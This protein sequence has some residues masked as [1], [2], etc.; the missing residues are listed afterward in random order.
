MLGLKNRNTGL[1]LAWSH[2]LD[3]WARERLLLYKSNGKDYVLSTS[4]KACLTELYKKFLFMS[5]NSISKLVF[6]EIDSAVILA[7]T[8]IKEWAFSAWAQQTLLNNVICT[9]IYLF[10][11]S[12][13]SFGGV[14]NIPKKW[15]KLFDSF[16]LTY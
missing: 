13:S 1:I 15:L 4:Q 5:A 2:I 9:R 16:T 7:L 14:Q 8:F 10:F 3:T 6:Q 11:D 12:L